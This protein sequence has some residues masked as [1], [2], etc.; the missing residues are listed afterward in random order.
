[1]RSPQ[2]S[3]NALAS[4]PPLPLGYGSVPKIPSHTIPAPEP[5]PLHPA[6]A[7]ASNTKPSAIPANTFP[8][9]PPF[10]Q[11]LSPAPRLAPPPSAPASPHSFLARR[12]TV[13]GCHA[14]RAPRGAALRPANA[15]AFRSVRAPPLPQPSAP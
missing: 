6:S 5:A 4:A 2:D 7:D 15:T 13:P 3:V 9:G 1:M 12:D 8:P 10:P 11:K 14:V